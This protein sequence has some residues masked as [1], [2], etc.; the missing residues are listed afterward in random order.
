MQKLKL[1]FPLS[2]T[3]SSRFRLSC[4]S[5]LLSSFSSFMK[6]L[7]NVKRLLSIGT[8]SE[9]EVFIAYEEKNGNKMSG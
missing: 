5:S 1:Y 4:F 7:P 2:L 6:G 8:G 3:V 9:T